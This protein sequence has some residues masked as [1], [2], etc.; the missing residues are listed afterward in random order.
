[1]GQGAV[2]IDIRNILVCLDEFWQSFRKLLGRVIDAS[3]DMSALFVLVCMLGFVLPRFFMVWRGRG[4]AARV[5]FG[6]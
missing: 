4:R 1:L 3:W 6:G 5:N 2:E